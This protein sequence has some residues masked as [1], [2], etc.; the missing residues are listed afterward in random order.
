MLYLSIFKVHTQSNFYFCIDFLHCS[1]LL[2]FSGFWMPRYL[3]SVTR[4]LQFYK[5]LSCWTR[6]HTTWHFD[7]ACDD[8]KQNKV[9][10][11]YIINEKT[12]NNQRENLEKM[13]EGRIP[14]KEVSKDCYVLLLHCY[15][16]CPSL[17][18]N[19]S[20]HVNK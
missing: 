9:G 7:T 8:H 6:K 19:I 4:T 3:N 12:K 5:L 10:Q 18:L 14:K 1:V 16:P 11:R 13:H 15:K 20:W 2:V 17:S